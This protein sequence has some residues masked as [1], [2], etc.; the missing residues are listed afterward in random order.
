[1]TRILL[2]ISIPGLPV[3]LFCGLVLL[4]PA[5][6]AAPT[7][8]PKPATRA[9]ATVTATTVAG[10]LECPTIRERLDGMLMP[11]FRNGVPVYPER[12]K[13]ARAASLPVSTRS[14]YD[15]QDARLTKGGNASYAINWRANA[16]ASPEVRWLEINAECTAANDPQRP[17]LKFPPPPKA[18]CAALAAQQKAMDVYL[19]T[20]A[21]QYAP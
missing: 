10:T 2:A 6:E 21:T 8:K 7:V 16:T 11:C 13:G 1:M 4:L 12:E 14:V 20:L 17:K 18:L 19:G 5:A 3:V 9:A 15:W